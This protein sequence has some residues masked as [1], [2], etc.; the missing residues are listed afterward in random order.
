MFLASHFANSMCH[1]WQALCHLSILC[2]DLQTSANFLDH[3]HVLSKGG[4]RTQSSRLT[5]ME[6]HFTLQIL[7]ECAAEGLSL[8]EM[9]S[10]SVPPTHQL[11]G[12]E[13]QGLR[14]AFDQNVAATQGRHTR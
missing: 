10:P 2:L 8:G 14:L 1:D 13:S 6:L 3:H 7:V 11:V 9:S 5:S 12:L 4:G